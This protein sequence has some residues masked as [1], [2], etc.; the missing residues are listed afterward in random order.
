MRIRKCELSE[1]VG[2]LPEVEPWMAA[3]ADQG[4]DLF[5]CALG[6]EPRSLALPARLA[7]SGGRFAVAMK[8]KF[9]TNRSENATNEPELDRYLTLIAS[10]VYEMEVD[11]PDFTREFAAVLGQTRRAVRRVVSAYGCKCLCE[12]PYS[13]LYEGR[14]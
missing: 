1:I 2:E 12:P 9:S 3:D 11:R 6:F 10:S 7:Q 4:A 5:I 13:T 8:L 14:P